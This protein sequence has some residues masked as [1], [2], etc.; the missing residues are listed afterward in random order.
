[1]IYCEDKVDSFMVKP[2]DILYARPEAIR[3]LAMSMLVNIA[4]SNTDM[5]IDYAEEYE[6]KREIEGLFECINDTALDTLEDQIEELHSALRS[7]LKTIRVN[8]RVRRLD[9]D[10]D[11]KL[12]DI[13]VD[14][15]FNS[16]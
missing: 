14:L 9:Y 4:E 13:T 10:D 2:N 7:M 3:K 1:M 12:I 15:K 8:P 16:V 6:N 5:V 11:G